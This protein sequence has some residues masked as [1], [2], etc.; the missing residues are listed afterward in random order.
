MKRRELTVLLLTMTLTTNLGITDVFHA[1]S[2]TSDQETQINTEI[3]T[4]NDIESETGIE[5]LDTQV[6]TEEEDDEDIEMRFFPEISTFEFKTMTSGSEAFNIKNLNSSKVVTAEH[7]LV[8]KLTTQNVLGY[9]CTATAAMTVVGND[10]YCIRTVPKQE[11]VSKKYP[12]VLHIIKNFATNPV[13]STVVIETA[14]GSQYIAAH[15][16]SL[17]HSEDNG[18]ITFY[19]ATG[20]LPDTSEFTD[21][22]IKGNQIVCFGTDGKIFKKYSYT[23]KV[24]SV[25]YAGKDTDGKKLFLINRGTKSGGYY[26]YILAKENGNKVERIKNYHFKEIQL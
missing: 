19:M 17:S 23:E 6:Y 21:E 16:N 14:G 8:A 20:N 4:E 2:I 22:A 15:A 1:S 11:G 13:E 5:W 7:K 9:N 18:K 26:F 12:V 3:E 10:L 24:H 25:N